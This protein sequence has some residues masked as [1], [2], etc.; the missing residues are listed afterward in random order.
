MSRILTRREKKHSLSNFLS[1][2]RTSPQ[3]C[4]WQ[5]SHRNR[6]RSYQHSFYVGILHFNNP[7]VSIKTY[8]F[9]L[10]QMAG[11]LDGRICFLQTAIDSFSIAGILN[12]FKLY[13]EQ[14]KIINGVLGKLNNI[15]VIKVKIQ[16]CNFGKFKS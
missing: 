1:H 12:Y 11:R 3:L 5:G 15:F 14:E 9:P 6:C 8:L 4:V 16:A 13:N 7:Q 2:V 10:P